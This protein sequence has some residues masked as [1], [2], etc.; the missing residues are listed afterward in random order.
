MKRDGTLFDVTSVLEEDIIKICIRLGHIHPVGVLHYSATELIILFSSADNM[1]HATCGAI[2]ATVL[3]E[4]AIAVRAS[5]PSKTHVRAYMTTLGGKPSRTKLPPLEGGCHL[6][7]GNPHSGGEILHHLQVDLGDLAD[8]ELHQ[9]MEDFCWEVALHELNAPTQ[10]PPPTPWGNPAES[11]DPDADDQEVTFLRGVGYPRTTIPTSC[12]HMARWRMG[13][14][15]TTPQ[16]PTPAQP[17]VGMGHLI[18]TLAS[19]LHLGTLRIHTFS[20]K[21]TPGKRMRYHLNN[22][23]MRSGA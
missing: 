8:H 4:E 13:S 12:S 3:R 6:P 5:A 22:G 21:A 9:L 17:N 7:A 16:P 19:G 23:T 14:P 11:G 10:R 20:C 15:G 2:K 1:Q 18:N